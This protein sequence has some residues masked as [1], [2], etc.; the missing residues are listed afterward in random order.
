M[1]VDNKNATVVIQDG[2]TTPATI[3]ASAVLAAGPVVAKPRTPPRK[4]RAAPPT[5]APEPEPMPEAIVSAEQ[6]RAAAAFHQRAIQILEE[7]GGEDYA[8][9]LLQQCLSMDPFNTQ[10]RQTLRDLNAKAGGGTFQR[11]F[12]SLNVLAIKSKL[13]LA[14]SS[15]SWR[16]VLEL[17]EEILA[18]QPADVDAHLQMAEAAKELRLPV[19]GLWLLDRGRERAPDNVSLLRASALLHE[20]CQNW[21]KAVTL[22]EKIRGLDPD[23]L[24][25]SHKINV[26]LT[27]DHIAQHRSKR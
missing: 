12:G 9:Q 8:R 18:R 7:G 15:S 22:W 14:R 1:D 23:N 6:A 19:F 21:R 17:G 13:R 16:K 27:K 5:P 2:K 4:R 25:A 24:E 10:Y 20:D 11:W 26:V 3:Q